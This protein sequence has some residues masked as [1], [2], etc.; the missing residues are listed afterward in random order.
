MIPLALSA[1]ISLSAASRLNANSVATSTLMGSVNARMWGSER[2]NTSAMTDHGS[3][4]PAS[5]SSRRAT[6]LIMRIPVSTLTA[7]KKGA[8]WARRM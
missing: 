7:K 8:T 2:T 1:V 4:F 5:A 3:P 6:V